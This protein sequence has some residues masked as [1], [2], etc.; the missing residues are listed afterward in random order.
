MESRPGDELVAVPMDIDSSDRLLIGTTGG[1][2]KMIDVVVV[3]NWA[4]APEPIGV[5]TKWECS[6]WIAESKPAAGM[7]SSLVGS[8]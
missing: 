4:T 1:G 5:G 8:G 3:R 7:R 6:A 2:G